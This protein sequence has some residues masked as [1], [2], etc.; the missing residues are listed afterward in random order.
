MIKFMGI[1][2]G[3]VR[4]S[5]GFPVIYGDIEKFIQFANKFLNKRITLKAQHVTKH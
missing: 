4:V 3:A 1:A 2:R 5:L